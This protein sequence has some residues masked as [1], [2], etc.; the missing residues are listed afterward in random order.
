M[1]CINAVSFH[2]D[3]SIESI[4]GKVRRAGFD[5]IEVSRPPFFNK[6]TTPHT[7]R[8]FTAFAAEQGLALH[9]FDCWVDVLPFGAMR[10]TVEGFR[11][12]VDF[13]R[14]LDL[15]FIISHDAWCEDATDQSPAASLRTHV[16]LFRR[17]ADMCLDAGLNLVFEPHPNTLSMDNR[18]CIDFIDGLERPN[19]GVL[20]D[21]C[22]YGVGQP[23]GYVESIA[24]LGSRIR[25]IH[26][27]DGDR[28]TYALHLPLG[29]GE[30]NQEA[31][32]AAMQAIPFRG[33][34]TNDLFNYPMLEDG[35]CRNAP[36][37]RDVER[38][39]GVAPFNK[40]AST[41][42]Q[43]LLSTSPARS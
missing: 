22:H 40:Y 33:T 35:A 41:S 15:R 9:G 13:A 19:V 8:R 18:W 10:E 24:I 29:D 30:L 25:H 4:C 23:D 20:Y 3:A 43:E 12:A 6:L 17:V 16:E 5:T 7:R 28:K 27:S 14:E 32:T 37:I 26:F 11:A 21:C 38:A 34:L 42:A 39:L 2:E 31:I 36:K 1:P